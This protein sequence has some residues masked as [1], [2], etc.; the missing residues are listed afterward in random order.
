MYFLK[1]WECF[2]LFLYN[3]QGDWDEL[4]GELV[5]VPLLN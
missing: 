1:N 3:Y 2:C 5:G 4:P